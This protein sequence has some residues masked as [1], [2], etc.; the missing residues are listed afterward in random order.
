MLSDA[1]VAHDAQLFIATRP[2]V[3]DLRAMVD[4]AW[5]L[6]VVQAEYEKF[7]HDFGVARTDHLLARQIALV[8]AWRR[9]PPSTRRCPESCSPPGGVAPRPPRSLPVGTPSGRRRPARNGSGSTLTRTEHLPSTSAGPPDRPVLDLVDGVAHCPGHV[10]DSANRAGRRLAAHGPDGMP[11]PAYRP[12]YQQTTEEAHCDLAL[13][14]P[15]RTA[16]RPAQGSDRTHCTWSR[17]MLATVQAGGPDGH[18]LA[19]TFRTYRIWPLRPPSS[20]GLGHRPFKAAARVRIPLGVLVDVL[21]R[22][23]RGLRGG[24][25]RARRDLNVT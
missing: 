20:S 13:M 1:G 6:D 5:N 15:L 16:R 2:G 12:R 22:G 8:H 23:L 3:G 10:A 24:S 19:P 21:V 18:V 14:P 11:G 4:D 25:R 7:L 17:P 9:F